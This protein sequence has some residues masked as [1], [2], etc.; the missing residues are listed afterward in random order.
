MSGAIKWIKF[1]NHVINPAFI[2]KIDVSPKKIIIYVASTHLYGFSLFGRG[3]IQ[4]AETAFTVE[5]EG[6]T[7]NGYK[8]VQKWLEELP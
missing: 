5:S 7:A 2:T 6:Q 3:S 8:M 4:A 1:R